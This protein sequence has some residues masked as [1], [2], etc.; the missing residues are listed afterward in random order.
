MLLV[1]AIGVAIAAFLYSWSF[2]VVDRCL[3]AG[4]RWNGVSKSCEMNAVSAPQ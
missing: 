2:V 3:D 1:A 4:G